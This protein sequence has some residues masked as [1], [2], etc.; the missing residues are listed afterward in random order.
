M[1]TTETS[2][3]DSSGDVTRSMELLWGGGERPTRGPKP[4]LT[5]DRIT[6]AAVALADAEGLAAVSMRRLSQELGTG[7]MSLYRYV[8]GKAELLALMLDRVQRPTED[9][10]PFTGTWRDAVEAY[11]HETLAQYRAHPWLLQVNQARPVLGP[12]AVGNLEKVVSRIEPM[13]LDGPEL[14]GVMVM[15]EAY[16][17]GAARS[18][19]QEIEAQRTTGL[20]DEAFWTAQ[21]PFLEKA[22]QSG[23]YPTVA[24]LSEDTFSPDFDHFAFGLQRI[25]DGLDALVA[26]RAKR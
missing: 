16:V 3:S 15:V 21:Q 23:D 13:G 7:T 11:A 8:P 26:Q 25:L 4:A 17:T 20:T 5:L 10:E 22:M 14:I 19:A 12:S 18:Q 9:P 6:T 2:G 1:S 24:G